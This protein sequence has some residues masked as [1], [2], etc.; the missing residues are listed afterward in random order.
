MNSINI[1]A[2]SPAQQD[3]IAAVTSQAVKE[4]KAKK[5]KALQ[6]NRKH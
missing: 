1:S 4:V 3:D 5:Q 6:I 2:M